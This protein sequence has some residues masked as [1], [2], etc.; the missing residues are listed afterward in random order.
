MKEFFTILA[1]TKT[2]TNLTPFARKDIKIYV[3]LQVCSK[4]R[5]EK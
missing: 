3:D 2:D 1:D 5:E 4:K